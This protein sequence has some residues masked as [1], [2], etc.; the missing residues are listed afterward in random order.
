[1]VAGRIRRVSHSVGAHVARSSV[2]QV[3]GMVKLVVVA[4]GRRRVLLLLLLLMMAL[5]MRA[6]LLL[7]RRQRRVQAGRRC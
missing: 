2:G 6:L 3:V 5:M 7:Y 4:R 1:M